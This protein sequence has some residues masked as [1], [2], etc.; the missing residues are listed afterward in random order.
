MPD[1]FDS[2]G[3]TLKTLTELREELVEGFQGIYGDDIN[4]DQNSPDGQQINIWAQ[5]GVDIR[6]IVQQVNSGFDPDQAAGRILDQRVALNGIKR[7]GGTFTTTPVDITTDRAVNLVGLDD[8]SDELEPTV[9]NLYTVKDDAGTQYYLLSSVSIGA[10]GTQSL[11]FRAAEIGQVE[12]QTNTITTPVTVIAGVTVI[13]NPSGASNIGVDEETDAN[14]KIRRRGAVSIPSIANINGLQAALSNL[15]GV[16]IA[17]VR[18]NPNTDPVDS[19]GTPI[20]FIW[21]IVDGGDETEIAETIAARKTHGAGMRG[22]EQVDLE[23]SDG[24]PLP[25]FFDRPTSQDLYIRFSLSLPGGVVDTDFIKTSIVE[26]LFWQVGSD[27]VG[28]QITSYVQGINPD[29][30]ITGM[31]VSDDNATWLEVVSPASISNRFIND[32]SR[33]TIT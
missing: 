14:L 30:V 25:I 20:H 7:T 3:L 26:N 27:A 10:A 9:S 19:D 2:A 29:Y 13:N 32:Q 12:V 16:T 6:E 31:Q 5:G 22:N 17:I 11:E 28:S 24:R 1:S 15:D 23:Y 18:E 33:I 21:A 4:V 8:Q